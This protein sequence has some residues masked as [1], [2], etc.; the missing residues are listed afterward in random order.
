M[1]LGDEHVCLRLGVSCSIHR[2][3]THLNGTLVAMPTPAMRSANP[4]SPPA[5]STGPNRA[6]SVQPRP[7][8]R[9]Q[10][11]VPTNIGAGEDG[12]RKRDDASMALPSAS[13]RTSMGLPRRGAPRA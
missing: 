5:Q 3:H 9:H 8:H 7:A 12:S 2:L 10:R 1:P 11:L 13:D 4:G 6:V